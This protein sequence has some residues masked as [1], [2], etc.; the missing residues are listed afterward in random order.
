MTSGFRLIIGNL[1]N[2]NDIAKVAVSIAHR[3]ILRLQYWLK[4]LS[5]VPNW[6]F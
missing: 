5:D 6:K 3:C 4:A 1:N 2:K